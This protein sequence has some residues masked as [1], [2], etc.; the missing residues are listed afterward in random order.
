MNKF[1]RHIRQMLLNQNRFGKYLMY[2]LG[3]IF[4][5]MVGIFLAFELSNWGEIRSRK[6]FETEILT[7]IEENLVQDADA[8]QS[9]LA[10]SRKAMKASEVLISAMS[11]NQAVDSV[12]YLLGD[13]INFQ[14][15]KSQSSAFEVLK[16]RGIDHVQK[17]ELQ[18]ALIT[19]YDEVLYKTYEALSDIE[20]AFNNDWIPVIKSDFSD[21]KWKVYATP[22]NPKEFF[23]KPSTSI[24]IKFFLNNRDGQVEQIERALAKIN[25]IRGLMN[26]P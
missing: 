13:I 2:A 9:I 19:Y 5:V 16:A 10:E 25:E 15:F 3:E 23:Q 20:K 17:E 7:L 8:L 11:A 1:F 26:N 22:S 12:N 21:F 6:K 24:L 4:L 18:L 14:R